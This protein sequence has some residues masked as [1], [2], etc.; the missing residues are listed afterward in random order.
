VL[1]I[2]VNVLYDKSAILVTVL[3]DKSVIVEN[4][5]YDKSVI[6]VNVF[7]D[8]P[9]ILENTIAEKYDISE[10]PPVATENAVDI[11]TTAPLNT[12]K[13]VLFALDIPVTKLL[14]SVRSCDILVTLKAL[15]VEYVLNIEEYRKPGWFVLIYV[16]TLVD[17]ALISPFTWPDRED[18]LELTVL[19]AELSWT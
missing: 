5:L 14:R 3:Y 19:M 13:L 2:L 4:V 10:N 12:E 9:K 11:L 18:I 1:A 16:K 15:F 7:V 6:L 17:N 8:S